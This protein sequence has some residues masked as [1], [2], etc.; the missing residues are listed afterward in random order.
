[1]FPTLI[2]RIFDPFFLVIFIFFLAFIQSG[3]L[4]WNLVRMMTAFLGVCVIPPALLLFWAVKTKRVTNW[5][6]SD[7]KQRVRVLSIFVLFLI[8]DYFFIQYIGTPLMKQVFIFLLFSFLGFFLITFVW[9]ISGH[10]MTATLTLALL[11]RW[12]GSGVLPL[13]LILFPLG[14]SRIVL[15][16]HTLGEVIG[17]AV[18]AIVISS[19]AHLMQLI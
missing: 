6:V 16:R 5:D 9:K 8:F 10:M 15:K 3:V 4:G 19:I 2:S 17:G 14:W 18:Y 12:L 13:L 7:R 1:M 11:V